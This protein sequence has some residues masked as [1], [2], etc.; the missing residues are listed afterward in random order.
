[1][2]WDLFCSVCTGMTGE[3]DNYEDAVFFS[4]FVRDLE[5]LSAIYNNDNM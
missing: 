1:M 5:A 2:T 3:D 4:F